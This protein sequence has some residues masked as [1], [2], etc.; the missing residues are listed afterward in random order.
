MSEHGVLS[1]K[2]RRAGYL[3]LALLCL[4]TVTYFL[5]DY[6]GIYSH[7]QEVKVIHIPV[8]SGSPSPISHEDAVGGIIGGTKE[9]NTDDLTDTPTDDLTDG[10][11]EANTNSS[12]VAAPEVIED[13]VVDDA[14][15]GATNAS[16]GGSLK[17]DYLSFCMAVK[18]QSADLPEFLIH[19]YYNMGIRRFYIMDDGSNPPLSTV[20]DYGIPREAII[21]NYHDPSKHVRYMQLSIYNE[22]V[23]LYGAN[24][25]WMAFVDTD[26]F[27][28]TPG[29][30][31]LHEFLRTFEHNETVGA[32]AINWRVHT[33]A[34]LLHR[35]ESNRKSFDACIF[36]DVEH[37]GSGSN[38]K[39]VKAIVKTS[40]FVSSFS[41]H[42]FNTKN[43]TITVGELG[44]VVDNSPY[45]MP[46]TRERVALHHYELKSR[47]Q[48]EQKVNRSNAMS[49]P[50]GWT[51]WDNMEALP[52]VE[53][54]EM[55]NYEP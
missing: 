51:F 19:H 28:D 55:E 43:G 27:F 1:M 23:R 44:D 38:N 8:S 49:D 33:S 22:C 35:P 26:E 13:H 4:V 52:Q 39:H 31:T 45:R 15:G 6:D 34:G 32:I 18:D 48:F 5:F 47:E 36:D 3:F 20:A 9:A 53:C 37:T 29:N 25:T 46:I 11:T 21:F 16:T 41:P 17:D 12:T 2:S 30:E 14:V 42:Q 10:A 40:A 54:R 50:K 7:T 24:H